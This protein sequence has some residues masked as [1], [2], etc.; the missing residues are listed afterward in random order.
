M[1]FRKTKTF[2]FLLAA[3]SACVATLSAQEKHGASPGQN[4]RKPDGKP[5]DMSKP[6]KVF[7]MMGQSN[8]FGMGDVSPAD[9][10]GTLEYLTRTEKK[11]PHLVDDAGNWTAR[12]DVRYIQVMENKGKM[13]MMHD[14]WLTVKGKLIGPEVQFGY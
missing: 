4:L 5:A 14:E 8:M 7:I 13:Q 1:K 9:K 12:A 3:I 10:K 6:V 2:T 11:Y